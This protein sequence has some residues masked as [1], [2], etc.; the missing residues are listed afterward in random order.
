M[1]RACMS[2]CV[3]TYSPGHVR[4][5]VAVSV[6]AVSVVAVSAVPIETKHQTETT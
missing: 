1:Y 2:M 3:A 5:M 6:V 4:E